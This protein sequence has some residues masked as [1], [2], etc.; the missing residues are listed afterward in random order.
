MRYLE[1]D[2]NTVWERGQY[3]HFTYSMGTRPVYALYIQYGNEATSAAFSPEFT[4]QRAQIISMTTPLILNVVIVSTKHLLHV[5]HCQQN[6]LV[7]F[8]IH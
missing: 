5:Y 4:G 8:N 7:E 6:I 1:S 3:T 2:V